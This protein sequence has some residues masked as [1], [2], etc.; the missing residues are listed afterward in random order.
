LRAIGDSRELSSILVFKGGNALDFLWSA[1]RSTKDLDFST[2]DSAM[3]GEHLRKLLDRTL[4]VAKTKLAIHAR[5]QTIERQPPG[6][7]RHFASFFLKIAFALA[8]QI[9]L[10]N[11]IANQQDCP[12]VVPI[13]VSLHESICESIAIDIEATHPI[14]VSTLEDIVAEK[15]R[16]L[17]QQ[18]IRNRH[19]SQDLLD[20]AVIL[21]TKPGIDLAKVSAFLLTK[22]A[23]RNVPVSKTAFRAKDLSERA[24]EG[25]DDLRTKTRNLFVPFDEAVIALLSF[26]DRLMIPEDNDSL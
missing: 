10:Q 19:R 9:P 21:R 1:N 8:D 20:I 13:D 22:A 16:A 14:L 12:Q 2:K 3:T 15:L 26:V 6:D 23:A 5:V 25:Y 18:S 24:H 17:L 7:D 11:K 4:L